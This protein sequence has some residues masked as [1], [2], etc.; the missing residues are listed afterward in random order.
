M[1]KTELLAALSAGKYPM[2]FSK[3]RAFETSPDYFVRYCLRET[4]RTKAM[5]FGSMLHCL[6]LEP[7][8]FSKQ[9][10]VMPDGVKLNT[11]EGREAFFEFLKSVAEVT[12]FEAA[13]GRSATFRD[14]KAFADHIELAHGIE[15][16]NNTDKAKAFAQ[17]E[18]ILSD[19]RAAAIVSEASELE[20]FVEFELAG[21][22][23]RGKIDILNGGDIAD[24]KTVAD[25]DPRGRKLYWKLRDEGYFLQQHI[26]RAALG[27]P[28]ENRIICVDGE[29]QVS[30]VR[31]GQDTTLEAEA[32]FN[33]LITAFRLCQFQ[34]LWAQSFGFWS[35][36][37]EFNV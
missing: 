26:Y 21:F 31:L 4:K 16:V 30:V 22:A 8:A 14:H 18:A 36:D 11:N 2:S 25:A 29:F 13:L 12:E 17:A 32:D 33:K 35:E 19:K 10:A 5:R 37:G 27:V 20:K 23:W 6:V 28:G 1:T 7:D 9:Y 3:L 34:D 15:F 24:L